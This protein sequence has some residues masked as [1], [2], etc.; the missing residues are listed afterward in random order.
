MRPNSSEFS[1]TLKLN[2]SA[3][4]S[5]HLFGRQTVIRQPCYYIALYQE[6]QRGKSSSPLPTPSL[7][8]IHILW[9]RWRVECDTSYRRKLTKFMNFRKEQSY[10]ASNIFCSTQNFHSYIPALHFPNNPL[11]LKL[12]L[13]TTIQ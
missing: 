1:W 9:D 12:I 5:S 7:T 6:N 11:P 8:T 4:I 13:I 10:F 2:W 3:Y